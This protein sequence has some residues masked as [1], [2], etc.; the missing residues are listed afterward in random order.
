MK[1][2][3]VE[4][5]IEREGA[6]LTIDDVKVLTIE[7]KA[8]AKIRM[9]DE[10]LKRILDEFPQIK[11]GKT[12]LINL[13]RDEEIT[14]ILRLIKEIS[15]KLG[16]ECIRVTIKEDDRGVD[17]SDDMMIYTVFNI[18]GRMT[19]NL[20]VIYEMKNFKPQKTF[21]YYFSFLGCVCTAEKLK[22]GN[23]G[24]VWDLPRNDIGE[25]LSPG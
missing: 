16:L 24:G 15:K 5:F 22:L 14:D 11:I 8:E 2:K 6:V 23:A 4:Y 9:T 18:F 3:V 7:M 19:E 1:E 10:E 25:E 12:L 17:W 13:S 21:G 20:Y